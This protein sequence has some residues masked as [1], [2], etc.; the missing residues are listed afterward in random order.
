MN[1]SSHYHYSKVIEKSDHKFKSDDELQLEKDKNKHTFEDLL[2]QQRSAK[3]NN[4]KTNLKQIIKK[5]F[6]VGDEVDRL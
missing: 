6:K 3:F 4:I 2:N 5:N 1:L